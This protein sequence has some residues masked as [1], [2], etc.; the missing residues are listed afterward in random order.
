LALKIELTQAAQNDA[1]QIYVRSAVDF[2]LN[3]AKAYRAD[4]TRAATLLADFPGVGTKT[5]SGAR[6]YRVKSHRLIYKA[7]GDTLLILRILHI[8]QLPPGLD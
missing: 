8:R 7:S 3:Q 2:G 5:P 6:T 1:R 4:I